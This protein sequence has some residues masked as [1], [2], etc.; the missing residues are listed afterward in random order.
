M[1]K[2]IKCVKKKKLDQ[3]VKFGLVA[4]PAWAYVPLFLTICCNIS[5]T[6]WKYQMMHQKV[7][8]S[9]VNVTKCNVIKLLMHCL[10][11]EHVCLSHIRRIF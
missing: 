9:Q 3:H 10:V 2:N 1:S 8:K 7:K 5:G 11:H 4:S 6:T